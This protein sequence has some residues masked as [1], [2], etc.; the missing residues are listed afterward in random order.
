LDG[1]SAE[2]LVTGLWVP[3]GITLDIGAGKMYWAH[4][5]TSD[6]DQN[7]RI[8]RANLNGS[9]VEDVFV[10]NDLWMPIQPALALGAGKIYW[11]G[12]WLDAGEI[13]RADLDGSNPEL[14]ISVTFDFVT[15][16]A[17]DR[18]ASHVYWTKNGAIWRT[19]IDQCGDWIEIVGDSNA[20]ALVIDFTPDVVPALS[21]WGVVAMTL[22]LMTLGTL[23]F[24]MRRS[25]GR[26]RHLPS[27]PERHV[28]G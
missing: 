8:Q 14:L 23:V 17:L 22:L 9:E 18:T 25:D 12:F 20:E 1:S 21:E 27:M 11:S 7:D 26:P 13:G 4:R 2:D 19:A 5:I 6:P 3:R 15:G 10:G 28:R 16:I 24:R